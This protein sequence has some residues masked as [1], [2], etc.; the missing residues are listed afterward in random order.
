M[1]KQDTKFYWRVK[2]GYSTSDQ[3][4]IE[5]T[6]LEK[7]IYAQLTGNPVQLNNSFINGRNIISITPHWH[8][9]TGWY[10]Y[11]EPNDG[12]DWKQIERDCPKFDGRLEH[13]KS[14]VQFLL[15]NGRTNEIGKNVSLPEIKQIEENTHP[16]SE[17]TKAL[18]D[19]FKI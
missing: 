3:V 14:R 17:A 19:K 4:S 1:I 12:D 15:Q 18:A 7:A 8:K 2:Y 6:E 11:Y 9:Y 16:F 13:Y 5:E 10:D